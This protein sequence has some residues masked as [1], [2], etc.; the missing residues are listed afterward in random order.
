MLVPARSRSRA[1]WV[2][3]GRRSFRLV[4]VLSP[5]CAPGGSTQLGPWSVVC[6]AAP[7]ANPPGLCRADQYPAGP[8][9]ND[10][11]SQPGHTAQ[12][13][14]WAALTR[15]GQFYPILPPACG[16][17]PGQGGGGLARPRRLTSLPLLHK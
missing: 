2:S 8:P 9:A 12:D 14:A 15:L 13:G 5:L 10:T 6:M 17:L 16:R 1:L 4:P 11:A 3:D 7:A